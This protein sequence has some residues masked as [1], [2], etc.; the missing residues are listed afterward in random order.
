[1]DGLTLQFET[2]WSGDVRILKASRTRLF[3]NILRL[4]FQTKRKREFQQYNDGVGYFEDVMFGY[5]KVYNF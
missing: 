2:F 1:M 3:T 5:E 4:K